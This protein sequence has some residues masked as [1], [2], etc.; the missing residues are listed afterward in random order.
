MHDISMQAGIKIDSIYGVWV[1]D[2][3]MI[4]AMPVNFKNPTDSTTGN[5][6]NPEPGTIWS[7]QYTAPY[8]YEK[9]TMPL[10]TP[11]DIANLDTLEE[12]SFVP[13]TNS[14]YIYPGKNIPTP[15]NVRVRVRSN[16]LNFAYSPGFIFKNIHFYA[17]AIYFDH[18]D[19]ITIEDSKFSHSWEPDLR[20]DDCLLYTSPSPRDS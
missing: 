9:R 13:E 16:F 8:E 20:H 15:T 14:L 1:D 7:L 17:G 19:Y 10:Y 4:P 2:R 12:W 5:Q 11:G 18:S 6:D 3:Y